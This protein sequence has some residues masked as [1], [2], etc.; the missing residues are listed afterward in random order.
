MAVTENTEYSYY[1]IKDRCRAGL[2]KYLDQAFK[3]APD[4]SDPKI[5][6]IGC[7][8]GVPSLWLAGH[9]SGSITCIDSDARALGFLQHKISTAAKI[10]SIETRNLSFD[11][12]P[13]GVESYDI[14]LAEGFLNV[15]GFRAGFVKCAGLLKPGGCFVIHDEYRDHN[16]KVAFIAENRCTLA[17]TI[18]LD[19]TIWWNDYYHQLETEITKQENLPLRGLF[20]SEIAEISQ[21]RENPALF[22]SIYYIVVK[23]L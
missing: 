23:S 9:L 14:L 2:L 17:G 22:R 12:L 1:S 4:Y 3:I 8:T 20:D 13:E 19:E 16:D 11:D 21:Y 7:G 18:Y 6:D 5:L 15:V 10:I